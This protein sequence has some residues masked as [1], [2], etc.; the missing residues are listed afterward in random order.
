MRGCSVNTEKRLTAAALT[1]LCALLL[2]GPPAALECAA[3]E[4]GPPGREA[5]LP[6]PAALITEVYYNAAPGKGDEHVAVSNPGLSDAVDLSGWS[7]ASGASGLAFPAGTLLAPGATVRVTGNASDFLADTGRLPDFET[8][9]SRP[10]VRQALP[11]GKW[12]VMNNEGGS[13]ELRDAAGNAVDLFAWGRPFDGKGWSG[14]PAEA[15]SRGFLARR[16]QDGEGGWADTDSPADWP[17]GGVP[18]GRSDFRPGAFEAS[19]V[20]AFASPD[21]A[22][23]AVADGLDR[24]RSSIRLAVYQFES[25]PLAQKLA[26]ACRRGVSVRVLLEGAPVEGVSEQE[27]AVARLLHESGASVSFLASRP[28]S[29]MPARYAFLHAK[30]CVIDDAISIVSSENWKAT[31]IPSDNTYGNRGWGAVVESRDLAGYLGAVFD[32][33]AAPAVRDVIAYSPGGGTFGPPPAGFV[34]EES[35]PAGGYRPQLAPAAFGPNISVRPVLSPD[36]SS[37]GNS[38]LFGLIRSANRTL[39]V[40]MLS[41]PAKWGSGDGRRA[42]PLLEAVVEAARRGV[43]VRLLLDRTYLDS[44]G[45]A[46]ENAAALDRLS[47]AAASGGL[48]IEARFARIPGALKLHNKGVVVDGERTLVS[49]INWG[50]NSLCDNREVGLIIDSPG[51]AGYFESIFFADWNQS[52]PGPRPSAD[53][54]ADGEM[55]YWNARALV[56]GGFLAPAAIFMVLRRTR[57]GMARY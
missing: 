18:V 14:P 50:R 49:S 31:G 6:L 47:H 28:G 27:R 25:W 44:D 5:G 56:L 39:F 37:A 4:G 35:A 30:Y 55:R 13:V 57:R 42:N 38:S 54:P 2:A 45:A 20:T 48:D 36:T 29:R 22:F 41:C 7:L 21:C 11:S 34:P 10:E 12:P 16:A 40:E 3:S 9:G 46:E 1:W 32:L 23:G 8:A 52:A 19:K 26:A 51:V 15:L 17:A 53:G 24:A 43:K 33:D